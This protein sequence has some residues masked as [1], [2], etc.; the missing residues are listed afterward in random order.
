MTSHM[1]KFLHDVSRSTFSRSISL[2]A[3][4][5]ERP[6]CYLSAVLRKNSNMEFQ[7]G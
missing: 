2:R 4:N 7:M 6:R 5:G 1:R 3:K